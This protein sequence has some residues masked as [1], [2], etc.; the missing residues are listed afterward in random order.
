MQTQR[1]KKFIYEFKGTYT[2]HTAV[3]NTERLQKKLVFTKLWWKLNRACPPHGVDVS[4]LHSVG[5]Q[6][7][8]DLVLA[9]LVRSH[10]GLHLP[11]FLL[12]LCLPGLLL[13]G[14]LHLKLLPVLSG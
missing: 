4:E 13:V 1:K 11:A 12:L 10:P 5:A 8:L 9:D 7:L 14:H 6:Q 2:E 3:K